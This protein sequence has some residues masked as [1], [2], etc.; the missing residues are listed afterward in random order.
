MEQDQYRPPPDQTAA[1]KFWIDNRAGRQLGSQ[2]ADFAAGH[3]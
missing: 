3:L 1:A 2:V